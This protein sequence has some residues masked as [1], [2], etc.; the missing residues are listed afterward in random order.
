MSLCA[1]SSPPRDAAAWQRHVSDKV[2]RRFGVHEKN[3]PRR[4][5]RTSSIARSGLTHFPIHQQTRGRVMANPRQDERNPAQA[6][7]ETIRRTAAGAEE[8]SRHA[9]DAAQ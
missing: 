8:M 9:E 5:E 6:A 2:C 4:E 1:D 3:Q 7:Q